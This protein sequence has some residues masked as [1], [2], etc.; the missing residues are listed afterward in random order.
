[1]GWVNHT[2]FGGEKRFAEMVADAEKKTGRQ[3]KLP[4]K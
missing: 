2:Y 4:G 3:A 1:M